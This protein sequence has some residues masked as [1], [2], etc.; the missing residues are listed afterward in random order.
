MSWTAAST[1]RATAEGSDAVRDDDD[2][3]ARRILRERH[4]DLQGRLLRQPFESDVGHDAD[5][6]A[7]RARR[8]EPALLELLPDRIFTRPDRR[9]RLIDHHDPRGRLAVADRRRLARAGRACRAWRSSRR[10]RATSRRSACRAKRRRPVRRDEHRIPA[11]PF[12]RQRERQRGAGNA[13]HRAQPRVRQRAEKVR[14]R[15]SVHSSPASMNRSVSRWS[16]RKPAST[17]ASA[18]TVRIVRPAPVSS[19]IASAVSTTM[20]PRRRRCEPADAKPRRT[21]ANGATRDRR[22]RRPNA[23]KRA[24]HRCR[25]SP[26]RRT[27]KEAPVASRRT[28]SMRGVPSGATAIR[29][30]EQPR[31]DR[32]AERA[33]GGRYERALDEHLA[34]SRRRPPPSAARTAS[35]CWRAAPRAISRFATLTHATSSRQ[36]TAPSSTSRVCGFALP[37]DPPAA[38]PCRRRCS[39]SG[40]RARAPTPP[41]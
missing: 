9:E 32:D 13:G 40:A 26:P 12:D 34:A 2:D 11:G 14:R 22:R 27:R 38:P 36:P 19:T 23:G 30:A 17:F 6:L 37:G 5:N 4:V 25:R 1:A 7:P 20:S 21:A 16:V 35:S 3:R 24:E 8:I 15:G 28:S 10:R 39:Y 41:R 18:W 29:G 33:T 31:R